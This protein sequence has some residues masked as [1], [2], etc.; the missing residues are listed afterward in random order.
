MYR[1]FDGN[2]QLYR[3]PV[4]AQAGKKKHGAMKTLLHRWL[5]IWFLALALGVII[6]LC[7]CGVTFHFPQGDLTFQTYNPIQERKARRDALRYLQEISRIS[8]STYRA[9]RIEDSLSQNQKK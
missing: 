3:Y 2:I 7:S 8:D 9:W 5:P 6:G 4:G 1:V